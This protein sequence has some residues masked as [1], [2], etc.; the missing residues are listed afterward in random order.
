MKLDRSGNGHVYLSDAKKKFT[1]NEWEPVHTVSGPKVILL[2]NGHIPLVTSVSS[3]IKQ[4]Q[5]VNAKVHN[6]S[7]LF[8]VSGTYLQILRY[9]SSILGCIFTVS[10][11][12]LSI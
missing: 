9:L 10:S 4:S 8:V 2:A 7:L 6:V 11:H 12:F 5:H 1:D 3:V